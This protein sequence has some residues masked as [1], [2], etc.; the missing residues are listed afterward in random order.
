MGDCEAQELTLV[1]GTVDRVNYFQAAIKENDS[2]PLDLD[3][4]HARI[5]A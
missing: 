1:D 3:S 5:K 4:I 2:L